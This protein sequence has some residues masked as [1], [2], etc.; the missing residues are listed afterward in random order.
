MTTLVLG[1]GGFV[2]SAVA[3][4]LALLDYNRVIGL[5]H[6]EPIDGRVNGVRY[7][8]GDVFDPF[9]MYSAMSQADIVIC[10]VSYVGGDAERCTEVN[11]RGIANVARA[12]TDRGVERL[13]YVSTASVYGTGPFRNL[14]VDGA[15]LNPRSPASRSRAAG[16][17]HIR[18]AGGLVVRPHLIYGPGDRW[19]IPALVSIVGSFA[20]VI[21]DGSALL[22]TIHVDGLA[23]GIAQ[24]AHEPDFLRGET[25]HLNDSEPVPVIDILAREHDRT[26]WTVPATSIDRAAALGRAE[27]LGIERRYIDMISLDHWFRNGQRGNPTSSARSGG[28]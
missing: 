22:S 13:V 25:V 2:G 20:A 3:R 10:C 26:G 5:V 19:F 24:L 9:S 6:S 16:E 1:A 4:R 8:T 23:R 7:V 12:A 15:P 27:A 28:S 18:D 21:D 14:P 17:Q 11:D